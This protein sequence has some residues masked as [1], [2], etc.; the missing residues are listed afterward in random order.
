MDVAGPSKHDHPAL[1]DWRPRIFDPL[2]AA[3]EMTPAVVEV[4][5]HDHVE[6]QE[7]SGL[8]EGAVVHAEVG[9]L[10]AAVAEDD[11][12]ISSEVGHTNRPRLPIQ[13]SVGE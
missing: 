13:H 12:A 8:Q 3:A 1:S 7:L 9:V 11:R 4:V 10:A 5:Q 6:V 2:K